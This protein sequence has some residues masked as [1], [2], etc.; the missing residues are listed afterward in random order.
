MNGSAYEG[1]ETTVSKALKCVLL[2]IVISRRYQV[3]CSLGKDL[4][5]G[6]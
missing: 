2:L 3:K 5:C 4:Q 6:T 1:E